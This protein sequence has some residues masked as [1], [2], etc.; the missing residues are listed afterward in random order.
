MRGAPGQVRTENDPP[1]DSTTVPRKPERAAQAV[2]GNGV[3]V[4][5]VRLPPVHDT[6]KQ[7]L[8][9][10]LIQIAREKGVSTYVGMARAAGLPLR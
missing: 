3:H 8:V 2:A 10:M 9:S 1:A 7:G 6:R 4:A 5:V